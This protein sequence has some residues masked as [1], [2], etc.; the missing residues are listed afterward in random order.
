M[1]VLKW[2][3][4]IFILTMTIK[5]IMNIINAYGINFVKIFQDIWEKFR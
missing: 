4:A 3:I 2:V 5:I 1:F